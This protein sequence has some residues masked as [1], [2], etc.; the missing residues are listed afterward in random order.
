V[1]IFP[2]NN[3]PIQNPLGG[4]YAIGAAPARLSIDMSAVMRLV[5]VWM[6]LGLLVTAVTALFIRSNEALML[7]IASSG[8]M[9]GVVIFQLVM[10]LALSFALNKISPSV[11]GILFL[12]YAASVGVTMSLVLYVYSGASV[13]MAFGTTAVLFGA[14]TI[15][16]F[17]TKMDLTK[18]RTFL[19]MGLIGLIVATLLNVFLFRSSGFD[20][21]LSYFGVL[22]F[23]ALTAYDTYQIKQMAESGEMASA[24]GDMVLKLS[25]FG[26]LKLYL[27]FINLFL[28]LLRIFGRRD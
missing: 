18:W 25:I 3:S 8:L 17:T 24:G 28:Y 12:V 2:N 4:D 26:A 7:S 21:M 11:A 1:S 6:G 22:L 5:Y 20:L 27:D 10:V 9:I 14:M 15:F 23:T 19:F 16:A 13:V